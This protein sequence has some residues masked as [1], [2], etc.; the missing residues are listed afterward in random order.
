MPPTLYDLFI[1][2]VNV[3]PP[4]LAGIVFDYT[5]NPDIACVI[6]A[7]KQ[8]SLAFELPSARLFPKQPITIELGLDRHVLDIMVVNPNNPLKFKRTVQS[9]FTINGVLWWLRCALEQIL[10]TNEVDR[11]MWRFNWISRPPHS[12]ESVLE[13]LNSY[14]DN[15]IRT[16]SRVEAELE[17]M[18][19]E[20]CN[21]PKMQWNVAYSYHLYRIFQ[22]IF[23]ISICSSRIQPCDI[24][25]HVLAMFDS[26]NEP[27]RIACVSTIITEYR[28]RVANK[29]NITPTTITIDE[30]LM[31][32]WLP[33]MSKTHWAYHYHKGQNARQSKSETHDIYIRR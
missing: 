29:Y 31:V 9:I 14:L 28:E 12:V 3:I 19:Q 24:I 13:R 23:E 11:C 4:V 1:S 32:M 25:D 5:I 16:C 20:Y 18:V 17:L 8:G 30:A 21:V 2:A 27:A 10:T 15:C 6:D 7:L 22:S 33:D 26:T